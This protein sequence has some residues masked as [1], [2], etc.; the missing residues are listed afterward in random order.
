MSMPAEML[1]RPPSDTQHS[2]RRNMSGGSASAVP[3]VAAH[4]GS[5]FANLLRQDTPAAPAAPVSGGATFRAPVNTTTLGTQRAAMPATA[6]EKPVPGPTAGTTPAM[7][8]QA[9]LPLTASDRL[10]ASANSTLSVRQ[11][12]VVAAQNAAP[13]SQPQAAPAS[14]PQAAPASQPQSAPAIRANNGG[15]GGARS[16]ID[17]AR[18]QAL[19]IMEPVN[20]ESVFGVSG[21][22]NTLRNLRTVFGG[23]SLRAPV[24]P[25]DNNGLPGIP[26]QTAQINLLQNAARRRQGQ[27]VG[28]R[29]ILSRDL[30]GPA[31]PVRS[32][33]TSQP[34]AVQ[35]NGDLGKLAARFESGAAGI[36]AIGYDRNGGTSYG[37][38]QIASRV[39]SMDSFLKFLDTAA[40]DIAKSLRGAGP[41]NTGSRRGAM[42]DMWRKIAAEQPDRFEALQEKFIYDSHYKPALEGILAKTSLTESQLSGAM[43]EVLWSTA[44]QHGPAGAV[45]IFSRAARHLGDTAGKNFDTRLISNIYDIRA[46]QF[47]SSTE[48]VQNSVRNRMRQEKQLAL[49]MLKAQNSVA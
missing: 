1:I 38:Y 22:M 40:P 9:A 25:Q 11:P 13:A 18:T 48:Q 19:S 16:G 10:P 41:A 49:N 26:L 5:P 7:V 28:G 8:A 12:R 2:L 37:K 46:Q 15:Q 14:Q 39:G 23:T 24:M 21:N 35:A 31:C 30:D 45:R 44:V 6:P 32:A 4:N 29:P 34:A 17:F 27:P 33:T 42:P 20:T 36:A 43:Q 47:G 3:F